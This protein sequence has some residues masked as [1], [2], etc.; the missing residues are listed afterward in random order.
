MAKQA[1]GRRFVLPLR[2]PYGAGR[3][4]IRRSRDCVLDLGIPY[5]HAAKLNSDLFQRAGLVERLA[6]S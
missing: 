5:G 4:L 3:R 6:A 1:G 2:L